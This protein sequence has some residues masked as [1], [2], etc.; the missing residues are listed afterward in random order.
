MFLHRFQRPA[1]F[2]DPLVIL[3]EFLRQIR[4][5]QIKIGSP[6]NQFPSPSQEVT[7]PLIHE[8]ETA[9]HI[10]SINR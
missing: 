6:N 3:S 4:R 9:F 10:F 1:C 2:Y 8:G 5:R 7:A